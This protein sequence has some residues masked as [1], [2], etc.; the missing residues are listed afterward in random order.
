MK[1]GG[2]G[3]GV[4]VGAIFWTVIKIKNIIKTKTKKIIKIKKI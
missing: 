3:V 2:V 1:L 4:G